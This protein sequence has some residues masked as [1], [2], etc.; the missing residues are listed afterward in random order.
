MAIAQDKA[1]VVPVQSMKLAKVADLI[2]GPAGT[3][4]RLTLVSPGE[5]ESRARVASFVRAELK[6]PKH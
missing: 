5:D 3:T 2:R 4:V 6:M 1:D